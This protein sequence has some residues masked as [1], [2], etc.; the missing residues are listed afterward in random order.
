[1]SDKR[2]GFFPFDAIDYKA[3]QAYLDK[4]AAAGWVLDGLPLKRLARF[5]PAQGR[6]H[7]VDL[8]LGGMGN[9]GP[10]PDYLQLCRDAGWELVKSARGM[11]LFRSLPGQRP[12]PLQTDG[13]LEANRFWKK[14][15]RRN[16][17]AWLILLAVGLI[18]G[19][20]MLF[21]D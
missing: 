9:D 19:F 2:W 10:D 3:A 20:D 6:Y 15:M 8:D 14:Y 4:K 12:A 17:L 7:A 21:F 18:L 5:V 13:E 16:V 11:L 1:M